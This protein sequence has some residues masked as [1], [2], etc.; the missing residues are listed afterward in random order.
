[1]L[2]L[3]LC[4]SSAYCIANAYS[5][6]QTI[7]TLNFSTLKSFCTILYVLHTSSTIAIVWFVRNCDVD[8][9]PTLTSYLGSIITCK[10]RWR[11]TFKYPT[12]LK[13]QYLST[14]LIHCARQISN[15]NDLAC[16]QHLRAF[17]SFQ[18]LF[19]ILVLTLEPKWVL[20]FVSIDAYACVQVG[21]NAYTMCFIC[22]N[23]FLFAKLASSLRH[24]VGV[25]LS[26]VKATCNVAD[27]SIPSKKNT[28]ILLKAHNFNCM[29]LT[30]SVTMS[31]CIVVDT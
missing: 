25:L 11:S 18:K 17:L 27:S 20:S 13:Q 14:L 23:V 10:G 22:M 2:F 8:S 5:P 28:R 4:C 6:A 3:F 7:S 1:M 12:L 15:E 29:C 16:A 19:V 9:P 24:G 21:K 30:S 31:I 26:D